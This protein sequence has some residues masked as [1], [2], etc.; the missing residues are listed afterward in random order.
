L[1]VKKTRDKIIINNIT[2]VLRTTESR[3]Y[4]LLLINDEKGVAI[5]AMAINGF[6][7]RETMFMNVIYT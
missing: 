5:I 3:S 7:Y 2:K 1:D 6:L 4:K